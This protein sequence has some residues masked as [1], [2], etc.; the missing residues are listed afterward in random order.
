MFKSVSFIPFG[1]IISG[2]ISSAFVCSAKVS[3]GISIST[4]LGLPVFNCVK[5]SFT[6]SGISEAFKILFLH[7]VTGAI[8]SI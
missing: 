8:L 5:A 7:F 6:A 2:S 3:G 1:E 4:G